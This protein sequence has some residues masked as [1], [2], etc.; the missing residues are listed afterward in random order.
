MKDSALLSSQSE[1]VK[2]WRFNTKK[3]IVESM[4]GKCQI[5]GYDRCLSNLA[6]H[7]KDPT[8][9][10][11]S[12]GGVRANPKSWNKITEELRKCVLL[13]HICHTEIH[14]NIIS[15]PENISSFN[16]EYANYKRNNL[17]L[18]KC[19]VCEGL[20][21]KQQKTCSVQCG[22]KLARKIDWDN[23]D[24]PQLLEKLSIVKIAEKLGCS[25]VAIHKRLK[26][27]N[28]K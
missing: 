5:C 8:K 11:F 22:G 3:R 23:V 18:D 2:L 26:K 20:K 12:L 13:C 15:L 1:K 27:L 28:L 25:D 16:E 21:P 9:K 4:G 14:E 24:L 10:D 17:F 19:L 6:L 7:H